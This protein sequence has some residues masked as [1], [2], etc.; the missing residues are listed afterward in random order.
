MRL[1]ILDDLGLV[2]AIEWQAEQFEART[3]ISCLVESF[4]DNLDLSLE[5]DTAIFRILQEALTNIIRHAQ[6]TR[7]NILIQ[8]NGEFVL[9]VRDNGRGITEEENAA[10]QSLGLLGMR[11]RAHFVGGRIEL[12]GVAGSGTVLTLRVPIHG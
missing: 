11:E 10:T 4:V 6:A 12:T 1:S 5:Q 2:A 9:E 8:G 7:V 3:G